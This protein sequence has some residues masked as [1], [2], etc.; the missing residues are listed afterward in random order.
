MLA[1]FISGLGTAL[2]VPAALFNNTDLQT[3]SRYNQL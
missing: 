2:L 1:F 3:G